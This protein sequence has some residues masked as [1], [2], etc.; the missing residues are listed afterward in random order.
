[1]SKFT[2]IRDEYGY[3]KA[4]A[5]GDQH[6]LQLIAGSTLNEKHA[7]LLVAMLNEIQAMKERN[8]K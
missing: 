8:R 1:M 5:A 4:I 6:V 3:A 2:V 7:V